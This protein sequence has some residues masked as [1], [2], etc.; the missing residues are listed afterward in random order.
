MLFQWVI[1]HRPGQAMYINSVSNKETSQSSSNVISV[2]NKTT[3]EIRDANYFS[4]IKCNKHH[5]SIALTN[6]FM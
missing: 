6:T 4:N 5:T 3:F 1:K 2:S